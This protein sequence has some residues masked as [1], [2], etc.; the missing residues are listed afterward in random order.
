MSTVGTRRII[1]RNGEDDFCLAK[2]GDILALQEKCEAGIMT[3][4]RRLETDAWYLNDVRETIRLGLIGGGMSPEKA[5]TTVK[6]HVD[7]NPNGLAPSVI[8]AH[9][10]LKAVLIGVPDDPVGKNPAAGAETQGQVSSTTTAASAAQ[11]SSESE[12][13]SDGQPEPPTTPPF[14]KSPPASMGTTAPTQTEQNSPSP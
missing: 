6:L 9:E 10:V 1:W 2:V 14:G 12:P 4:M 7:G 5:M 3:I 13:V 8:I 11:R